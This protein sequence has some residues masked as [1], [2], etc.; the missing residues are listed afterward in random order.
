MATW[1]NFKRDMRRVAK[2]QN[3]KYS[4]KRSKASKKK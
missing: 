3:A 4:P 2:K 1:A